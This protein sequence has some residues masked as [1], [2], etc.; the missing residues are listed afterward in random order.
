MTSPSSP[1]G[2]PLPQ[3]IRPSQEE[4]VLYI[5]WQDGHLGLLPFDY[6]RGACPCAACKGHHREIDQT[7]IVPKGGVDLVE[8]VTQGHYALR[9]FWSDA[10]QTGIYRYDYLRAL[11]RCEECLEGQR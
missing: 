1:R 10:H 11:C 7:Q 8:Y 6:L 4:R 9:F 5:K 2:Q 3:E